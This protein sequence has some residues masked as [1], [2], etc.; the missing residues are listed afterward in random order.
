[1]DSE[2]EMICT[3]N[4]QERRLR[5]D[6]NWMDLMRQLLTAEGRRKEKRKERMKQYRWTLAAV[7]VGRFLLLVMSAGLA[8][9][10]A[11]KWAA[12]GVLISALFLLSEYDL[13]GKIEDLRRG[14][15]C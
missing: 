13:Q 3:R 6:L 2:L 9:M 11:V 4:A 1:M 5:E 14:R 10:G 7:R 15:E 12:G 8:W